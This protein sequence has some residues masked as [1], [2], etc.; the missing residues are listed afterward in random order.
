MAAEAA[1]GSRASKASKG[2]DA[3][4]AR[5]SAKSRLKYHGGS[6]VAAAGARRIDEALF[7]QGQDQGH[8]LSEARRSD[9]SAL[10]SEEQRYFYHKARAKAEARAKKAEEHKNIGDKAVAKFTNSKEFK[11]IIKEKQK[12]AVQKALKI[13]QV[14]DLRKQS[15]KLMWNLTK[16]G[17]CHAR[18]QAIFFGA[19]V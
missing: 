4:K 9:I 10:L 11:N 12:I 15:T 7:P 18:P 5:K 19:R 13:K 6:E 16:T 1:R 17:N 8:V 2:S 14:D 3:S